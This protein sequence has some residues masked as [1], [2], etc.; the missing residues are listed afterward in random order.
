MV[1]FFQI[2]DLRLWEQEFN[3]HK[4]LEAKPSDTGLELRDKEAGSKLDLRFALLNPSQQQV[5]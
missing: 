5:G 4:Y 2:G 3:D 1:N